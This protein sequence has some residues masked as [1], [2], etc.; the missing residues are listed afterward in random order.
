[1]CSSMLT[2]R[3]WRPQF[4]PNHRQSA[5]TES[6]NLETVAGM[7]LVL[8]AGIV[9]SVALC[10]LQF[11]LAKYRDCHR[12]VS[13][14]M[15]PGAKTGQWSCHLVQTQTGQWSCHLVPTQVCG[16]VTWCRDR[17]VVMSPGA[18]TDGSV[19]MSILII[20][21]RILYVILCIHL[22]CVHS[23]VLCPCVASC[24]SCVLCLHV[25]LRVHTSH[26][27]TCAV[28]S[29]VPCVH[30]FRVLTRALCPRAGVC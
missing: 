1:M 22:C 16:H 9:L 24:V 20:V 7:Y 10:L 26:V 25:V 8:L 29:F 4:C 23:C 13:L 14:V 30:V 17:S 2:C 12:Q 27:F 3:W 18:E 21:L 6:L 5:T 15:S 28:C 11:C 19:V